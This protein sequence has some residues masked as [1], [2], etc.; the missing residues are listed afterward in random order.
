MSEYT[1]LLQKNG[2]K[3]KNEQIAYRKARRLPV[4]EKKED[5]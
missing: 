3:L 1:K 5:K 4:E 2:I